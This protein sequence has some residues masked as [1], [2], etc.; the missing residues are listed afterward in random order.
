MPS[1]LRFER[2]STS[3][4]R[5][6]QALYPKILLGVFW[7]NGFDGVLPTNP[8][9][10]SYNGV[11][12]NGMWFGFFGRVYISIS[13]KIPERARQR[14]RPSSLFYP[15]D[16]H[17]I[18]RY[19]ATVY[20]VVTPNRSCPGEAICYHVN[21]KGFLCQPPLQPFNSETHLGQNQQLVR[22]SSI[23]GE[24]PIHLLPSTSMWCQ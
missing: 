3:T 6:P 2:S 15:T 16:G 14:V 18:F 24:V 8:T 12:R 7:V 13:R 5:P 11:M 20:S 22:V 23:T 10:P 4:F 21:H 19:I 9:L 17:P 1:K